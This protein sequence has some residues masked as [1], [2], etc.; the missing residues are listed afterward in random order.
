ME[1][2]EEEPATGVSAVMEE[3]VRDGPSAGV[4]ALKGVR[5]GP[6]AGVLGFKKM[7]E[8]DVVLFMGEGVSGEYSQFQILMQL[9]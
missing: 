7:W 8:V 1:E 6:S 3:G 9:N 2:R 4:L 5:D